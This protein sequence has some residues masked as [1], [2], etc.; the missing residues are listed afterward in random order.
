MLPIGAKGIQRHT[1]MCCIFFSAST[2]GA[3][4]CEELHQFP[5]TSPINWDQVEE[6]SLRKPKMLSIKNFKKSKKYP[7]AQHKS[8]Y[9]RLTL[10]STHLT[11]RWAVPLNL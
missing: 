2:I 4:Q 8:T 10:L 6:K 11:F 1:V 9:H 5:S 7:A 3:R